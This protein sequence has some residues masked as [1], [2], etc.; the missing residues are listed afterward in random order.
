MRLQRHLWMIVIRMGE[1][2]VEQDK[3]ELYILN[4]IDKKEELSDAE[5]SKALDLY[6]VS[7]QK[8]A[9]LR[10]TQAIKSIIQLQDRY[11][12]IEWQQGLTEYQDDSFNNQPYEVKKVEYEKVIK[13]C[14]WHRV[15]V[16]DWHG[17]SMECRP[18]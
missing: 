15:N 12:C 1:S 13:V 7:I 18:R 4:K 11:F 14:E 9:N 17:K 16:E 6:T 3:F 2:K 8:G 10:W 5:I